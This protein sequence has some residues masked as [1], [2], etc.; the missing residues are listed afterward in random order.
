MEKRSSERTKNKNESNREKT[1][2]LE[3]GVGYNTPGITSWLLVVVI[4]EIVCYHEQVVRQN[5]KKEHDLCKVRECIS[6]NL[7][8]VKQME[9][10]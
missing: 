6:G 9:D 4:S 5:E 2:F 1:L 8:S 10:L 7:I 3:T